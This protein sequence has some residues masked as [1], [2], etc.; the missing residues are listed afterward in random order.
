MRWCECVCVCVCVC[1]YVLCACVCEI[2]Y[3]VS[4]VGRIWDIFTPHEKKIPGET[5]FLSDS[6]QQLKFPQV[7]D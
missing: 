5:F 7:N 4:R 2:V 3:D 6:H 1:V